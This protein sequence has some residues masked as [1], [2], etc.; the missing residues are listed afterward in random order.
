[1]AR[2]KIAERTRK[3]L[4]DLIR[5]LDKRRYERMKTW[6]L[7]RRVTNQEIIVAALD[8]LFRLSDDEREEAIA[9]VRK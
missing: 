1:M 4:F 5:S 3:G 8:R 9:S 7:G 2:K 6:G